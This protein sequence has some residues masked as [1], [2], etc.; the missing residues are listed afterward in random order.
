MPSAGLSASAELPVFITVTSDVSDSDKCAINNGGCNVLAVCNSTSGSATCTCL[1]GFT[2][3]GYNC[4]GK[5][6][7]A[8]F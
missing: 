1:E 6:S 8:I 7:L 5:S 4:T 2:G 3:N